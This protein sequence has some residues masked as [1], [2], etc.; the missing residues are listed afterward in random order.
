M[1]N[2][3]YKTTL[4]KQGA[5]APSKPPSNDTDLQDFENNHKANAL[6]VDEVLLSETTF[7]ITIDYATFVTHID[8]TVIV[9]ADVKYKDDTNI[10]EL[11]LLSNNTL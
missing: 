5:T 9:W 6:E 10:Y 4:I 8:G 2:Y 11:N 3:L 7:V 1:A